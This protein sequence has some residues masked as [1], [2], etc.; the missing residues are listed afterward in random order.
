MKTLLLSIVGIVCLTLIP[1]S[2]N[3]QSYHYKVNLQDCK[4][5]KITIELTGPKVSGDTAFFH[6]PMTVPGTYAILDY[7]KYIQKFTAFSSKGE[8]LK[9]TK[10]GNNTFVIV[11]GNDVQK[12][13]YTVEDSWDSKEKKNKIFEP[14]GT[15]FEAL[16]YFYINGGGLFGFF[17]KDVNSPFEISYMKPSELIGYTSLLEKSRTETSQLFYAPNYHAVIDNPVLFTAE[18]EQ[19]L[20]I[21]GTKVSVAS[22]Y[23]ESDSSAYLVKLK[24]DSAMVAIDQFVGGKLPVDNYSFLNYVVDY[25]DIGEMLMSGKIGIFGYLKIYRKMGG[26]GF[27]A[28]EHGN[29]SSYYL[30]D[31]G[32]NSYTGMLYETA[33]HEFLHI[34]AP[35]SLH[36]QYIGDFDY[37]NPIMSKHLWLYEGVTEYFSVLV[38]MQ[39]KLSSIE[40]TLERNLKEKIENSYS[41]PDSLPFTKMSANVFQKPYIDYYGQVYTRGAIMAMLLDIEIMRL[42]AG[43]KT[44]K[45]VI[46]ELCVKYGSNK[47]F[48][49]DAI[50]SEFVSLVHPDLQQFFD[51]YVTG[52]KA[53]PIEESFAKIG[54]SYSKSRTGFVPIDLLSK[55]ENDVIANRN[56]VVNN[57]ITIG[58]VGK[59]NTTGFKAGDKVDLNALKNC[60]LKE[61]GTYVEDGTVIQLPVQRGK[62]TVVLSFPAKFKQGTINNEISVMKTMTEEQ[63]RFFELW[64]TGK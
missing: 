26:Q 36:S 63:K 30:P 14:A 41:Y 10:K 5:D 20:K 49:E 39:G 53:L 6:F 15:G 11:P 19:I 40:E 33:I 8:K 47:S 32:H 60:F 31:F 28:L 9:V 29:S 21:Q 48:D 18:K 27:G 59:A 51:N 58:K 57:S 52:T 50:I 35:L 16:E 3:A 64:S 62:E 34:Y 42:T 61:D 1:V 55:E 54:I 25:R 7:G 24:I 45:T 2:I 44:L 43:K 37:T 4:K 38:S 12:I 23:K 56:V 17:N 22:Y 13:T 46:F